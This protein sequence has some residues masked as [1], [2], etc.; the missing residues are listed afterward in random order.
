M[1]PFKSRFIPSRRQFQHATNRTAV[2]L[3]NQ[4]GMPEKILRVTATEHIDSQ[5]TVG[6]DGAYLVADFVHMCDEQNSW[7][8]ST[9]RRIPQMQNQLSSF[10][11]HRRSMGIGL[12]SRACS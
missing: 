1:R 7:R 3:V 5:T 9:G 2:G 11:S 6:F 10:I 4:Y 8:L 12:G